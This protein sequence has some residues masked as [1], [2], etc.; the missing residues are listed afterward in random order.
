M[1]LG[2]NSAHHAV[3]YVNAQLGALWD[4]A[5]QCV[6]K[7]GKDLKPLER[8]RYDFALAEFHAGSRHRSKT[9]SKD[10]TMFSAVFNK[11]RL[12]FICNHEAVLYLHIKSGHV[13]LDFAKGESSGFVIN[14]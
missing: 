5:T 6:H 8:V 4:N 3:H 7:V 13:N 1:C 11:P 9:G 14:R 2:E 10:E 12:D